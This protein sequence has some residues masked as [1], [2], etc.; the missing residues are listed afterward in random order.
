[1]KEFAPKKGRLVPILPG[2]LDRQQ[3]RVGC[4]SFPK[5]CN[6]S[7]PAISSGEGEIPRHSLCIMGDGDIRPWC[8]AR[9]L[10]PPKS[11]MLVN[12]LRRFYLQFLGK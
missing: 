11:L 5:V 8:G 4:G 10:E 2:V 1:M 3:E 6:S 7:V 12:R 9:S